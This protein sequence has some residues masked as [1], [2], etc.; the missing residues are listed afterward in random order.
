MTFEGLKH[1]TPVL[2]LKY[3]GFFGQKIGLSVLC[4]ECKCF[5]SQI[6]CSKHNGVGNRSSHNKGA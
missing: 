6:D 5:S 2:L 1:Q 4:L 3:G